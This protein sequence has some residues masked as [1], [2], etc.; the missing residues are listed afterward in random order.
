MIEVIDQTSSALQPVEATPT[1]LDLRRAIE[2]PHLSAAAFQHPL[3]I[4]ATRNISKIPLLSRL[5]KKVSGTFF[6]RQVWLANIS[7]SVKL[8]PTQAGSIYQ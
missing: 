6:E 4:Q 5:M 3:D 2:F 7:G 8:G 1:A